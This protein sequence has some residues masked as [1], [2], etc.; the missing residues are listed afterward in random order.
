VDSRNAPGR[1]RGRN[2]ASI[3]RRKRRLKGV[4]SAS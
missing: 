4:L 3:R 1:F 2:L